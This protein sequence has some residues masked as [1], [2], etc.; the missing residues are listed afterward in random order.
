MAH[1]DPAMLQIFGLSP[2]KF[3]KMASKGVVL[4]DAEINAM[5]KFQVALADFELTIEKSFT[6]VLVAATPIMSQLAGALSDI[7]K[8]V[9]P[10]VTGGVGKAVGMEQQISRGKYAKAMLDYISMVPGS[11]LNFQ[12]Y[13]A[14][15]N[16]ITNITNNIQSTADPEEVARQVNEHIGHHTLKAIKHFNN[17]GR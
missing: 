1:V 2:D 15:G 5:M 11:P 4:N 8:F 9:G 7:V 6:P 10:M 3:N 17:G 12:A 14:A 16:L 13:K